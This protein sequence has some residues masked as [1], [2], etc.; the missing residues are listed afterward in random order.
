MYR[1]SIPNKKLVIYQVFAYGIIVLNILGFYL[2]NLKAGNNIINI[3]PVSIGVVG[4]LLY[5]F[6]RYRSKKLLLSIGVF[7]LLCAIFWLRI[8]VNGLLL[9]NILF[10]GLYTISKR[11]MIITVAQTGISYPSFPVKSLDWNALNN[12]ILKDDILTIDLNNNKVY[13]HLIDYPEGEISEADFNEFCH[14]QMQ[15]SS[16]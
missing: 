1:F 7:L 6:Y 3:L 4:I 12:I 9:L 16:T 2:Y 15:R 8:G 11:K 10:W 14:Q 13:Q 5:D